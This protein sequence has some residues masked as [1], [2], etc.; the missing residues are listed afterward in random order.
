[1]PQ[2]GIKTIKEILWNISI[3]PMIEAYLGNCNEKDKMKNDRL[4]PFRIAFG[5]E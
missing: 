4:K 3:G 1:M 5:I 2:K